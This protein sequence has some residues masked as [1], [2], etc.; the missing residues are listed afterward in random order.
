ML[1][2]LVLLAMENKVMDEKTIKI[3]NECKISLLA[4]LGND[5]TH[6]N[7]ISTMK[8]DNENKLI[9]ENYLTAKQKRIF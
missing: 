6:I 2:I 5:Y 1:I 8:I 9:W 3:I 7:L 4:T